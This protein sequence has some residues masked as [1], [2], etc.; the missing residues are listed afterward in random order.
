MQSL[1]VN[2][3]LIAMNI[4]NTHSYLITTFRRTP[5]ARIFLNS[6]FDIKSLHIPL[7]LPTFFY[8]GLCSWY[9]N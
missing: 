3:F 8:S 9:P 2:I 6:E 4:N 7:R 5:E 1:L